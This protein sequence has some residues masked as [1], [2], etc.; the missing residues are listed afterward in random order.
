MTTLDIHDVG[1]VKAPG[2]MVDQKTRPWGAFAHAQS[3]RDTVTRGQRRAYELMENVSRSRLA[4]LYLPYKTGHIDESTNSG[5]A[6]GAIALLPHLL[7]LIAGQP[8]LLDGAIKRLRP[9][10]WRGVRCSLK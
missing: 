8:P 5:N 1:W 3:D 4:R 10:R 9:A 6:L 2:T 7:L